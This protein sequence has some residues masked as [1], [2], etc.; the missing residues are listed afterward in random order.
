[1]QSKSLEE[2]LS[3][4]EMIARQQELEG[5]KSEGIKPLNSPVVAK[6]HTPIYVKSDDM[7]RG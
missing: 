3:V 2:Q 7:V 4:A 5:V 6:P 1:M